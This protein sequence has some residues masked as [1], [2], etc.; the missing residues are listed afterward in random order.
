M[1]N[2]YGNLGLTRSA[3]PEEIK[4]AYRALSIKN[5]PDR[6]PGDS[7]AE[8]R[9]KIIST[10]YN[11]LGDPQKRRYYDEFGEKSLAMGFDAEAARAAAAHQRIFEDLFVRPPVQKRGQDIAQMIEVPFVT[12]LRGGPI[13]LGHLGPNT[14]RIPRGTS[15][16]A[17]LR[18]KGAGGAGYPPGDLSLT[19]I[20]PPHPH[21][22]LVHS[23]DARPGTWPD[24][25]MTTHVTWRE[26][27]QGG[28][29]SI[30]T[31]WG[32]YAFQVNPN[33]RRQA[34]DLLQYIRIRGYGVRCPCPKSPPCGCVHGDLVVTLIPKAPEPGDQALRQ[35]LQRLQQNEDPRAEL[36]RSME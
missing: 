35:V 7:V 31:P 24:I 30:P 26:I 14:V 11:I 10:T 12:A 32:P 9:F 17:V 36:A 22:R 19:V 21:L 33:D 8:E 23:P 18:F 2:L 3:T 4:K 34:L 28:S 16:G 5:H 20:V 25:H 1:P 29:I 15:D 27:Y 6:N 13:N